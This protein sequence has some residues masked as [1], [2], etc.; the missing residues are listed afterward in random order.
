LTFLAHAFFLQFPLLDLFFSLLG[1]FFLE[2][3]RYFVVLDRFLFFISGN[4]FL[5][6]CA[7]I[8][9]SIF[10]LNR[11]MVGTIYSPMQFMDSAC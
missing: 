2:L 6:V 5:R 7:N 3:V 1:P 4:F 8:L 11:K 9:G 10:R